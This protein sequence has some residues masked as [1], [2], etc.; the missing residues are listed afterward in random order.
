MIVQ[1]IRFVVYI[2]SQ[3]DLVP[4]FVVTSYAYRIHTKDRLWRS[5]VFILALLATV[6]SVGFLLI[7]S[8]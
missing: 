7:G 5:F 2:W 3:E 6:A 1:Y 8:E 4:C